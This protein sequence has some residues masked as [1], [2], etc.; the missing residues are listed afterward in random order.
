MEYIYISGQR[1]P[2]ASLTTRFLGERC[3][4]LDFFL[5]TLHASEQLQQS[6]MGQKLMIFPIKSG[7]DDFGYKAPCKSS[8]GIRLIFQTP[9]PT[10]SWRSSPALEFVPITS[11]YS[12]RH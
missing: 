11:L 5:A 9:V 3:Q 7:S 12:T 10:N 1:P 2:M 4:F 8:G 6:L